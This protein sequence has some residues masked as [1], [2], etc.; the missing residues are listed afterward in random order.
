MPIAKQ[1][2]ISGEKRNYYQ[3]KSNIPSLSETSYCLLRFTENNQT[4]LSLELILT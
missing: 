2:S 3:M 4:T 1:Q